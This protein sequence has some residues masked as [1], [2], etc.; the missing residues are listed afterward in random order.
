MVHWTIVTMTATL[1]ASSVVDAAT[2]K[3]GATPPFEHMSRKDGD[4]HGVQG[5]GCVWSDR[6]D[7]GHPRDATWLMGMADDRAV[8]KRNGRYVLLK[9]MPGAKDMGPF[10]FD[11]WMSDGITIAV[12]KHG[13]ATR[14]GTASD[15]PAKLTVTEAG[16]T[17][18]YAGRVNCGT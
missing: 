12:R 1:M 11:R 3:A 18:T 5:A 7:K 15:Q 13:R 16:R 2:P 6:K 9:P 17:T 4:A 8:V 10:T 14:A